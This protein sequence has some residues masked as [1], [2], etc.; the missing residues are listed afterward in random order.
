MYELTDCIIKLSTEGGKDLELLCLSFSSVTN[1]LL[2]LV[3]GLSLYSTLSGL[4]SNGAIFALAIKFYTFSTHFLRHAFSETLLS[5]SVVHLRK[6]QDFQ[7]EK[8]R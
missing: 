7:G 3:F 2:F 5:S 1:T 4:T 6:F 8:T